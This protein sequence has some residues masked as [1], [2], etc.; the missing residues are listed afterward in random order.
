MCVCVYRMGERG[1]GCVDPVL[2]IIVIS[3]AIIFPLFLS[4]HT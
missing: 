1:Q 2:N 3:T 4:G